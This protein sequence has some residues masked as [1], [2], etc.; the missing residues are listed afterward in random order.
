MGEWRDCPANAA[1]INQRERMPSADAE[2]CSTAPTRAGMAMPG[3]AGAT[4]GPP[5][6]PRAGVRTPPSEI[7]GARL[8]PRPP[9][10]TSPEARA[11][12][13]PGRGGRRGGAPGASN[14]FG[15]PPGGASTAPPRLTREGDTHPPAADLRAPPTPLPGQEQENSPG[16]GLRAGGGAS[17]VLHCQTDSVSAVRDWVGSRVPNSS[18]LVELLRLDLGIEIEFDVACSFFFPPLP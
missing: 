5:R 17:T 10:C 16:P 11:R 12:R 9:I 13:A 14:H 15:A 2:K 18:R 8:C 3:P 7:R 4:G 6:G 1:P